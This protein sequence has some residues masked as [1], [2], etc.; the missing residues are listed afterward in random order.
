MVQDRIESDVL[1]LAQEFLAEMVGTQRTTPPDAKKA[2]RIG[3]T[4]RQAAD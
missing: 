1:N 4:V 2:G 3:S